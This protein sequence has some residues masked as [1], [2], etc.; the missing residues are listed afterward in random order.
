MVIP[1]TCYPTAY[2]TAKVLE[3]HPSTSMKGLSLLTQC[4]KATGSMRQGYVLKSHNLLG[5][6]G[7][8]HAG[9]ATYGLPQSYKSAPLLSLV[10]SLVA[11]H[12]P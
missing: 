10:A 6:H 9:A 4:G 1:Q 11:T 3:V 2:L 7:S 12:A 8:H 5:L